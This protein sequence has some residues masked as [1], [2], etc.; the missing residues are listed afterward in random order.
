MNHELQKSDA[1]QVKLRPG[2]T[3]GI[4]GGTARPA[5]SGVFA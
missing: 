3:I 1:K 5:L 4:L 2:D